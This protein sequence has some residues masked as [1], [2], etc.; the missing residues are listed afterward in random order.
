MKTFA[1]VF[2]I[3]IAFAIMTGIAYSVVSASGSSNNAP[4]FQRGGDEG[5][6]PRDG[7]Q[8]EFREHDRD[9]G[10]FGLW[11]GLLKNTLI[12]AVIVALIVLPRNF[13]QQK[14]RAMPVKIN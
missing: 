9:G 7:G 8:R 12:I 14:R 13:L 10:G 2:A 11:F 1:R 5:V 4:A 6:A 3:L